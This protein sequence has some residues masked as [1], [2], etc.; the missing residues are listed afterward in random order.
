MNLL[1]NRWKLKATVKWKK[2]MGLTVEDHHQQVKSKKVERNGG[3]FFLPLVWF[4]A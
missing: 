2:N 1:K 4:G 3:S